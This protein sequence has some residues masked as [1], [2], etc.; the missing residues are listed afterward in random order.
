MKSHYH[1][2]RNGNGNGRTRQLSAEQIEFLA[3][4]IV[5]RAERRVMDAQ[6]AETAVEPSEEDEP[7]L[8]LLP[9][10]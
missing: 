2:P 5:R 6:T 10:A 1:P 3:R 9:A 4:S 7:E 8:A